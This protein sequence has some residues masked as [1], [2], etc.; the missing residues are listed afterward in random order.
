MT[1][2]LPLRQ[3]WKLKC[4]LIV[5]L[6]ISLPNLLL[7]APDASRVNSRSSAIAFLNGFDPF[8]VNAFPS[9]HLLQLK[10]VQPRSAENPLTMAA[11]AFPLMKPF[12]LCGA[13]GYQRPDQELFHYFMLGALIEPK[14]SDSAMVNY[15]FAFQKRHADGPLLR[16]R[17][18]SIAAEI[19]RN[20]HHFS[21]AAGLEL[22]LEKG[23][24]NGYYPDDWFGMPYARFDWRKNSFHLK[25]N[26]HLWAF[27]YSK[28]LAL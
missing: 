25:S 5:I 27:S 24:V 15:R 16:M 8:T 23:M 2:E 9:E 17:R 1:E 26:G 12:S 21:L 10:I 3:L 20:I 11:F 4:L 19:W 18:F 28:G 22:N 7:A 14:Q 13:L 6:L